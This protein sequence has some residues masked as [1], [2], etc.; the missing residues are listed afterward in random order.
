[1]QARNWRWS[2][3]STQTAAPLVELPG[4]TNT[5][6]CFP[7]ENGSSKVIFSQANNPELLAVMLLIFPDLKLAAVKEKQLFLKDRKLT[8]VLNCKHRERKIL[9]SI[10]FLVR[11]TPNY[12]SFFL[13]R[14][15]RISVLENANYYQH[16]YEMY[17]L[18]VLSKRKNIL[19]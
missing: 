19:W 3:D 5:F 6:T 1:M 16:R 18:R 13:T 15:H 9:W 14:K 8:L 2:S 10:F 7:P 4:E 11:P 12:V 17:W